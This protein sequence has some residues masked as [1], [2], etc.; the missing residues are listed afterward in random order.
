[1]RHS[2]STFCSWKAREKGVSVGLRT[3]RPSPSTR[4][5]SEPC[6]VTEPREPDCTDGASVTPW[7]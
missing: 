4:P 5:T 1:M 6:T 3:Y 7:S 2:P